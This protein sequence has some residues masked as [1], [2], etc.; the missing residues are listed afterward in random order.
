MA[1]SSENIN[2]VA[3]RRRRRGMKSRNGVGAAA[4]HGDINAYD[5]GS[6]NSNHKTNKHYSHRRAPQRS[7]AACA[8]RNLASA[9]FPHL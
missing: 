8:T 7:M 9:T 4:W 5:N 2:G 3:W 6:G 1:R